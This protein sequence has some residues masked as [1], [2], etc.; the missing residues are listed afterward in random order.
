MLHFDERS[1]PVP[2]MAVRVL[3][4][5]DHRLISETVASFLE[6]NMKFS[7]TVTT[8]KNEALR[9]LKTDGAFDFVLLDLRLPRFIGLHAIQE[10]VDASG[11]GKVILFSGSV[12]PQTLASAKTMGVQ[13]FV[14]KTL[15]I[16]SLPSVIELIQ[17]GQMFYPV[18]PDATE[19]EN[20]KFSSLTDVEVYVLNSAA[21]GHSN[22]VIANDLGVREA[23]IKMHLRQLY[24]K[25]GARNRAHAV[26]I[27][28]AQFLIRD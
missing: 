4:V 24:N 10:V 17:S 1:R 28:R 18:E 22:K 15:G 25:L 2:K 11:E 26:S 23:S 21:S 3:I 8:N 16:Q 5:D 20:S 12:E 13:G 9:V 6:L 27:G 14:P 19:K 7:V